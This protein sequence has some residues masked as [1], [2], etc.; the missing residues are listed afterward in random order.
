MLPTNGVMIHFDSRGST[1][2]QNLQPR[3]SSLPLGTP[4]TPANELLSRSKHAVMCGQ[5]WHEDHNLMT[6]TSTEQ[7]AMVNKIPGT[8]Q[9]DMLVQSC[10]ILVALCVHMIARRL[11]NLAQSPA[12]MSTHRVTSTWQGCTSVSY[13]HMLDVLRM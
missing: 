3:V 10:H 2:G 5:F 7:H 9:K 4:L 8:C 11:Y 13:E 1:P 12:I 6:Q